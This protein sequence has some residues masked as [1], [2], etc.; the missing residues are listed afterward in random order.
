MKLLLITTLSSITISAQISA[1]KPLKTD[2]TK[3]DNSITKL[4]RMP[5]VK[6]KNPALY[7][8]LKAPKK[9]SELYKIP[10]LMDLKTPP[11]LAVK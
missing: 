4:Y 5:V 9:D 6:P 3:F 7:S 8:S 10:N 11:K 1:I 2:S